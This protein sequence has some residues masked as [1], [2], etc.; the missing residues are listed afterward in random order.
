MPA[1]L[2]SKNASSLKKV[3]PET[4]INIGLSFREA[5]ENFESE[6]IAKALEQTGGNKNKAAELLGLNRTTLVEKIKRRQVGV[7]G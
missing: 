7:N 6:L 2:I 1:Q 4:S 5:V 3:T